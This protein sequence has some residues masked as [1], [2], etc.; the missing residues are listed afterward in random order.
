M[1][2]INNYNVEVVE[3]EIVLPALPV[4]EHVLPFS[5]IDLTIPAV[6]IHVFFCYEKPS[7][8]SFTSVVSNLKSSL[9]K[10]LVSFDA[11]AGRLVTNG[12]GETEL[13]CNNKGVEFAK[14]YALTSLDQVKFYNP[15]AAVGNKLVPPTLAKDSQ[16]HGTPV[17]SVQVTEFSCGGIVVGCTFNHRVADSFSANMF[18]THWAN[19]SRNEPIEPITPN[20]TRSILVPRDP[21][22]H[23]SEFE[24]IYMK[25]Q[26]LQQ[27]IKQTPEPAKA[28]RIYYLGAKDIEKL[29]LS[30]NKDGNNYSKLEAFSAYFWK[31]LIQ[32]L[33]IEGTMHCHIGI[34]IDGRSRLKKMGM[35][36]NYFGNVVLT[37]FAVANVGNIKK[38]PLS[39]V[40]KLIHDAIYRAANEEYFQSVVDLV[41]M[42]KP[43]TVAAR[44]FV[45]RDEPILVVSSGLRFPLYEIDH[46]WGKPILANYYLP[47]SRGY[48]MPTPSPHGDG[49]WLIYVNF[50][51]DQLKAMESHPNFT[52]HK[53]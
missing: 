44:A 50:L 22:Y 30:A 23:S 37:S 40:A 10:A 25:L 8:T 52:L 16:G 31:L 19:I 14:A 13:V 36:A 46:G 33:D 34:P 35:P 2:I 48:V 4:Q 24:K 5:N 15:I 11:F 49:S 27:P 43:S 38:E 18:F 6:G 51:V 32:V 41:E 28:S 7:K 12:V 21:P 42:S 29:Q 3:R 47:F 20:F 9:S 17:F 45:Q 26:P 39:C 53:I 1:A